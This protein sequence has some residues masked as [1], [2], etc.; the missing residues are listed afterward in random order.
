MYAPAS[1]TPSSTARTVCVRT[2]ITTGK[3]ATVVT[4]VGG[5]TFAQSMAQKGHTDSYM[6]TQDRDRSVLT[7]IDMYIQALRRG[8]CCLGTSMQYT[9]IYHVKLC[10]ARTA[11]NNQDLLLAF[12]N[13]PL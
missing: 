5:S 1:V 7:C 9:V 12:N 11:S 10:G 8:Q 13:C 6:Y 2:C 3:G 4:G